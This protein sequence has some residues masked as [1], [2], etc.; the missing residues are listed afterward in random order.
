MS[1]TAPAGQA[2]APTAP[3]RMGTAVEPSQAAAYLDALGRWRDERHRELEALDRCCAV[4]PQR[5]RGHQ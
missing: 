2:T 5:R 4:L 3:G 1:L